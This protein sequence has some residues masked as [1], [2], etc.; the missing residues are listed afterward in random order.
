MSI[1]VTFQKIE[2]YQISTYSLNI[3]FNVVDFTTFSKG[4]PETPPRSL[5]LRLRVF[6]TQT[7]FFFDLSHFLP[8]PSQRKKHLF[9]NQIPFAALLCLSHSLKKPCFINTKYVLYLKSF[10]MGPFL[11]L[12]K[13]FTQRSPFSTAVIFIY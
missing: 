2:Y 8:L 10:P 12:L 3:L 4:Y 7:I 5:T 13:L 1:W 11:F 6:L 9:S